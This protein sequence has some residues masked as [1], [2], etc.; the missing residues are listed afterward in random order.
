MDYIRGVIEENPKNYQVWQHRRSIV[1]S[2]NE[3]QHEL[4]L[5]E[6]IL[7]GDAKNYHAWQHRQWA[8]KTF[9]LY[10]GELA[11]LDRLLQEDVRNNSA[12]NQRFF[13]VSHLADGTPFKGDLLRR[14]LDYAK[15]AIELA[16]GNESSWNYFRGI[17]DNAHADEVKDCRKSGLQFCERL[18][19][20]ARESSGENNKKK[21]SSY[22][23]AAIVDLLTENLENDENDPEVDLERA[24]S[25]CKELAEVHDKIRSEYWEFMMRDL[26]ARFGGN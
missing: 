2:L 15:K 22:L 6:I 9:N 18:L 14:E 5:C 21:I 13:I 24:L 16:P 11:Y 4:R 19:Q 7:A 8:I 20:K 3:P 26:K 17:L 1:E 25:L 10:D 23:L 12:W